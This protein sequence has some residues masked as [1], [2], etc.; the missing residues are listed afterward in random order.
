MLLDSRKTD[1]L[2][3]KWEHRAMFQG[4]RSRAHWGVVG[5]GLS[6]A[7][8]FFKAGQFMSIYPDLR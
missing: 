4:A 8:T 6:E 5:E 7:S 2:G 3:S 1:S